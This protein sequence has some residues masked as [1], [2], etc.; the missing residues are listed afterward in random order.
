[1]RTQ[2]TQ[3]IDAIQAAAAEDA[4][5]EDKER[6]AEACRTLGALF[7]ATPGTPL[8][9]QVPAPTPLA[10]AVEQARGASATAL[11]EGLITKLRSRLPPETDD[12]EPEARSVGLR[13]PFVPIPTRPNKGEGDG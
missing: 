2:T 6:G 1:M 11:L 8:V 9:S 10:Q 13:I 5:P 4:S 3:L 7:G 12:V